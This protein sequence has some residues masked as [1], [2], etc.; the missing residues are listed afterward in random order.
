MQKYRAFHCPMEILANIIEDN[1]IDLRKYKKLV[2]YTYNLNTVFQYKADKIRD[3]KQFKKVISIVQEY[4]KEVNKLDISKSDYSK[5]VDNLFD[6]CMIKLKNLSI[7]KS[8]MSSLIAYAFISNGDVRD[9]LL[10]VLYDKDAELFLNCFKKS[11]KNP[12]EHFENPV[13]RRD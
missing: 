5:N 11:T 7:N 2:S 6:S 10:T 9:R 3:S 12:A 4:D 1:V 8:T 13:D